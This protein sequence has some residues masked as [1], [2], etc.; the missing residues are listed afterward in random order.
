MSCSVDVTKCIRCAAC[1]TVAPQSF[2]VGAG[3]AR[4]TRQPATPAEHTA[5]AAA[6]ALCPT[7]AISVSGATGAVLEPQPARYRELVE[8][9]EGVRWK[10]S[11]LPW[12]TLDRAHLH[13][14]LIALV[15]EMAF[16]EQTTFSATQ[17]FMQAF[18]DDL[19]FSQWVS[20]WFYEE[21]RHPVALL[22]WLELAG[23]PPPGDDFVTR[24]RVSAPFMKSR[25]GTL[26][27]NVISEMFAAEAYRGMASHSPEPLLAVISQRIC[28]D[29]S[30]HGAS[31]FA[32][33]RAAL[34]TSSQPERDRLD[35][36][37]VL[38]F[39]LNESGSV[40]HPVNEAMAKMA[41]LRGAH[42]VLP[43]YQP[44]LQRVTRLV[45]LLTGLPLTQ[46]ADLQPLLLEHTAKLHAGAAR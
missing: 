29:E 15:R 21:T 32:Y 1:A 42:G 45:G 39:W 44:P 41:G 35:A 23:E 14:S 8:V 19:D 12:S 6:A 36:L 24:G 30:R 27:T 10:V 11:E 43:A 34:S 40:S 4:V 25:I 13:P 20:V 7:D 2:A 3:R 33:A 26:V 46:P 37:K 22:R 31:F 17:R 18:G 9:A 28:G 5:A 16:S 38:H